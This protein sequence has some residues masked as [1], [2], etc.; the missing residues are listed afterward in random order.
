MNQFKLALLIFG[1]LLSS[2]N[3]LNSQNSLEKEQPEYQN[4]EFDLIQE[5]IRDMYKWH[6][7]PLPT[8]IE[9][10]T[11]DA[12]SSY[13]GF[14]LDELQLTIDQLKASNLFS[15]N[16]IDNY[17]KIHLIIDEKL[18]NKEVEWLVGYLPPFGNGA[19]PWCNC[20]DIPYDDP[21]PWSL[22]Q[23]DI[24]NLNNKTGTLSWKWGRIEPNSGLGWEEFKYKFK[25]VKVNQEWK[26]DYL[27][28]FDFDEFTRFK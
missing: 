23:I 2:S 18:K 10:I 9:M 22:I 8:S 3:Q 16:F 4:E 7:T 26:I 24:I 14:N 25:V 11:D 5:L 28:G 20:Q 17:T 19:N 1:L 6:E 21:S 15:N 13:I 12:G 27:E